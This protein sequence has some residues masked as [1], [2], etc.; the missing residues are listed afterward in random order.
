MISV[1]A[2]QMIPEKPTITVICLSL[3]GGLAQLEDKLSVAKYEYSVQLRHN[4]GGL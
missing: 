3:P 2:E 4:V 1:P